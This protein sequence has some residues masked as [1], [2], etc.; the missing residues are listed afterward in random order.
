MTKTE[1]NKYKRMLEEKFDELSKAVRDREGIAI[2]KSPD[3]LDEV[4]HAAERE[5]AIRNLDRESQ[6]LRNVRAALRRIND[7][8]YGVCLHC[9]EDINPKRLNAVPWAPFCIQCQ[10][11][12]DRNR[13]ENLE[14]FEELMVA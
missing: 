12:A 8:T 6:L 5:L 13:D 2:E 14:M 10:E 9:E 7:G 3:A 11:L 1:L 4:Q